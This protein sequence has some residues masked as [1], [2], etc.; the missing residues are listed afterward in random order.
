[1]LT[2]TW[3]VVSSGPLRRIAPTNGGARTAIGPTAVSYIAA[4]E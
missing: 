1:M 2:E 3:S 4:A